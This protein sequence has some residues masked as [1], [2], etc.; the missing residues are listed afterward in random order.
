MVNDSYQILYSGN[1]HSSSVF[2]GLAEAVNKL[3]G[4]Q[5]IDE[6]LDSIINQLVSLKYNLKMHS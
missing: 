3:Q 2:D 1:S 4:V 5:G 6:D